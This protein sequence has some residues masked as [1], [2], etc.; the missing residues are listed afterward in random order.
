MPFP[1]TPSLKLRLLP[2]DTRLWHQYINDNFAALEAAITT[3]LDVQNIVGVWENSTAYTAGQRVVDPDAALIFECN[4]GHTSAASP[5]TFEEDRNANPTFW[6]APVQAARATGTWQPLTN[7]LPNDFVIANGT[8]FAVALIGHTSSA[9]FAV[10]EP[11]KWAVLI[12]TSS[13]QNVPSTVGHEGNYLNVSGGNAT[14]ASIAQM[15]VDLGLGTAAFSPS[16]DFAGAAHT[17]VSTNITDST[18]AGRTLITAADASAQRSALGLGSIALLSSILYANIQNVTDA[19]L[20]GRSAGSAGSMQEITIGSGL[21]LA[22]GSL[23]LAATP[24]AYVHAHKNGTN[25][26]NIASTDTKVTF[27]TETADDGGDFNSGTSTFTAPRTAD[28][29]VTAQLDMDPVGAA[30]T[31]VWGVIYV[32]GAAVRFT[33]VRAESTS[34]YHAV[35][36]ISV[37]RITAG[38]TLE[39]YAG[40]SGATANG[41][42]SGTANNSYLI[43][44]EL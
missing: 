35:Q 23:S 3:Y 24:K 13:L 18:A 15:I 16:T 14:W 44:R 40:D 21:T 22:S 10:D 34:A 38:Q 6:K 8:K 9:S 27:G 32:N 37:V 4:Q 11:T 19:R 29:L 41:I 7:Y 43:I 5:T 12:D 31:L 30:N 17:H 39:I 36:L 20:L 1:T 26:T 42:V 2:F 28:Y 33:G 25:Q